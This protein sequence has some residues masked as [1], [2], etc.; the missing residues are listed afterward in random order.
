MG[1]ILRP[2]FYRQV[3]CWWVCWKLKSLPPSLFYP[4]CHLGLSSPFHP[5]ILQDHEV[6]PLIFQGPPLILFL[7]LC[8]LPACLLFPLALSKPC[9]PTTSVLSPQIHSGPFLLPS[10]L[11]WL[12]S[13]LC[14]WLGLQSPVTLTLFHGEKHMCNFLDVYMS[15]TCNS[16]C[17]NHCFHFTQC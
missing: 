1:A 2:Q 10:P 11:C 5:C 16:E 14:I 12:N 17:P 9:T 15:I 8:F 7:F 3:E 13:S 4:P 6:L